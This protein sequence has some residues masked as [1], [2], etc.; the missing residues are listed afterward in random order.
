MTRSPAHPAPSSPGQG[1]RAPAREARRPSR[2]LRMVVSS[3]L[4]VVTVGGLIGWWIWS[5]LHVRTNNAYVVGNI[6]PV[7]SQISG[8]VVA[9]YT[10]DNMIVKAGD[11]LAQIDPVPWQLAVDQ[12]L[13]DLAQLR[14]QERA[15]EIGVRL[16]RQERKAFLEGAQ[17]RLAEADR[18]AGASA[19]EVQSRR[20]L[21]E[22][23]QELLAASRAQLPGLVARQENA[24]DYFARFS[25]LAASGDIPGQDRDNREADYREAASKVESLRSEIASNE[26]QVLSS[27]L[28]LE[29]STIRLE[30]S[31]R[32]R[33]GAVAAV[34]QAEAE[35]LQPDIRIA[36]LDAVRSQVLQAEAKLRTARIN[37]SYCLIRA[38]QG[39][40]VSRRTIQL[41]ETLAVKQPFLSIVPLDFADVWVVANLRE[42]QMDRVRDGNPATI[43]LDAIPERSFHGWVESV[44]GGT[45]SVF[46]LFPP[47]NATGNFV[48]VVQRLP[49]RIRFAEPENY[50]N[51]IRPGMSAVVRIDDSRRV[52]R[53][54]RTW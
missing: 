29:E 42:D 8:M 39:G 44:S 10:D 5:R 49:V 11:A 47:D 27:E 17:A 52:R 48:R 13:A 3:T 54:D 28:Q 18:N 36:N 51:R 20:R 7:S 2:V 35:Q 12:A 46:S 53:S 30:Q 38:P 31:R 15:S 50:Q 26:R 19:V 32:A 43:T 1:P 14:A 25:R 33:E 6:T 22:K 4:L 37:L 41:G 40:I 45:G 9:L 34:G 23:E 24:R 16:I 21:H